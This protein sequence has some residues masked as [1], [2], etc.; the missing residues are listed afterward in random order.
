M[1]N[2]YLW[3]TKAHC[4]TKWAHVNCVLR[5]RIPYIV[6][7]S[8]CQV[9]FFS[10][11]C[12]LL[13]G[14]DLGS[15]IFLYVLFTPGLERMFGRNV[16]LVHCKH[17]PKISM[18]ST[19]Q[20]HPR[21]LSSQPGIST[22]VSMAKDHTRSKWARSQLWNQCQNQTQLDQLITVIVY[23]NLRLIY[24]RINQ[25]YCMNYCESPVRFTSIYIDL[26]R[27]TSIYIVLIVLI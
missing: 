26:H 11:W 18:H 12:F 27:F 5:L 19:A 2:G 20:N 13:F 25:N 9:L 24:Y 21:D 3:Q 6:S 15:T 1:I 17:I 10:G 22:A 23:L 4:R 7:W 8:Y 16:K 14:V